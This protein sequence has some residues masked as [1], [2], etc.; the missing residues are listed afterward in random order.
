M[1]QIETQV[2]SSFRILSESFPY[3]FRI[4]SFLMAGNATIAT[5]QRQIQN[6]R[7]RT[8]FAW[9][10]YYSSLNEEHTEAI[11]QHRRLVE[12]ITEEAVPT[13]I[14]TIL[15]EMSDELKR[16]WSCP[17]CLDFIPEGGLE[18]TSCG[19]FYC[20]PCVTALKDNAHAGADVQCAVCR[21]KIK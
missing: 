4:L 2:F 21:R 8:G 17:I 6:E 7:R 10:K 13:H 19:H 5:L 12:T 20:R 11:S 18:I 9:A 15:T 1:A 16:K 3:P 14:K